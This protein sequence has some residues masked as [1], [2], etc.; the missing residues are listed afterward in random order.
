[1]LSTSTDLLET[2]VISER[3]LQYE[4]WKTN[5]VTFD[6]S[7][8]LYKLHPSISAFNLRHNKKIKKYY[9][10]YSVENQFYYVAGLLVIIL[11][12]TTGFYIGQILLSSA[13]K[14]C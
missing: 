9:L 7:Y 11:G 14:C 2:V 6:H 4:T 3:N 8:I 5:S 10:F 1:M 12:T 13:E